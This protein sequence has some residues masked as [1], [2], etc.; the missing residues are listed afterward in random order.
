F[1]S[2][3][4]LVAVTGALGLVASGSL[5]FS[6][7]K[8]SYTLGFFSETVLAFGEMVFKKHSR[9]VF[10]T[11]FLWPTLL[12]EVANCY[13]VVVLSA[14]ALSKL[15]YFLLP[16]HTSRDLA[17]WITKA[18]LLGRWLGSKLQALLLV[19]GAD[20]EMWLYKHL[21]DLAED[22]EPTAV[23]YVDPY[24]PLEVQVEFHYDHARQHA[25]RSIINGKPV[26]C[27]MGDLVAAGVGPVP[28]GF[29]LS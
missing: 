25:C 27:R 1:S 14:Y 17:W 20:R 10:A 3:C 16:I 13:C 18:S 26:F 21:G 12:Y 5:A 7:P 23:P 29:Q 4:A 19:L 11:L 2:E 24:F 9:I 8:I 15:C 6:A 22:P 28:P